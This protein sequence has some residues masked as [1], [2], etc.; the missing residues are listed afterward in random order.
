[1]LEWSGG[2]HAWTTTL[3]RAFGGP[4]GVLLAA[5][6]S[7]LAFY[8]VAFALRP[9]GEHGA[10]VLSD[11]GELPLE[12]I[13]VLLA[14]AAAGRHSSRAGRLAWT[15]LAL[16]IATNLAANSI[17]ASYDLAGKQPFPS[18]ADAFYLAFY[19]L[20]FVGIVL[21]PTA[22]RRGDLL[23]WRLVANV[24]TV[25]LGGA[26]AVTHFILVP[27]LG[28]LGNDPVASAISLAY[29]VGDLALLA[30][31]ATISS[32]RPLRRDRAAISLLAMAVVAWFLADLFFAIESADGGYTVGSGSDLLWVLGDVAVIVAARSQLLVPR[33]T[34]RDAEAGSPL[35][36]AR[37]GP[38]AMLA[39]GLVTLVMA[40]VTAGLEILVL[41]GLAVPL[42]ALVVARQ[43][44]DERERRRVEAA[45]LA[46]QES[47]AHAAATL[48]RR[49]A[50]TGLPNRGRLTEVLTTEI[51][52]ARLTGRPVSLVF[53][54]LNMFKA[55]NDTFGHL[56]GDSL[57]VEVGRRLGISIRSNDI[58]ARLGGDEFAIVLPGTG[59]ENG[60]EVAGWARQTIERPFFVGGNQVA[61]TAA[62][63]LATYPDHG[64]LNDDQLMHQADTAMYHAKRHRLGPAAYTA[65]L[66][67]G[68]N[69]MTLLAEL[70]EAIATERIGA[71]FQPI[72]DRKTGRTIGVEALARWNHPRRGLLTPAS[73]VPLATQTGLVREL[74]AVILTRACLEARRLADRGLGVLFSVNLSRDSAQDPGFPERIRHALESSRIPPASL[75]IE[76]NEEGL[77]DDPFQ[78]GMF[79]STMREMGVRL[80]IDDFGTGF[81][82]LARV[83]D[84]RVDCLKID[85]RF[86][87]SL[88]ASPE[89]AAV[90]EAVVG[91]AHRLGMVTVAEG[92]E[93]AATLAELDRL[94]CDFTQG[95]HISRPIDPSSLE[96]YLRAEADRFGEP[97]PGA[98]GSW[99]GALRRIGAPAVSPDLRAGT[100]IQRA[101]GS[102]G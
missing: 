16:A 80:A 65:A 43:L 36:L 6:A 9:W 19:P 100:T 89:D 40:A 15:L 67:D 23:H 99:T 78:A 93:D 82:S 63:G 73:F 41:S 4:S 28:S 71:Y 90:V 29:P 26:M 17:Y 61:V 27:V 34:P 83:R 49:D 5:G 2:D 55:V 59:T 75:V 62:F 13:G 42:I 60:L 37:I 18:L 45:L 32:R 69:G 48:A 52:V 68:E 79:V 66:D 77:I 10:L 53:V 14:I 95:Y 25:V 39:L 57:L 72:R 97:V 31:I 30:A 8:A 86:V 92:V 54:D 35:R 91:L 46:E 38:Y 50:L 3:R 21:L 81:S 70:R 98:A 88:C 101:P 1:M 44:A 56:A 94:G 76:L 7:Y 11:L 22:S 64:A 96:R 20:T 33:G 102:L 85:Q 47:A 51:E 12:I 87:T 84:Y 74:D 58:V 24:A